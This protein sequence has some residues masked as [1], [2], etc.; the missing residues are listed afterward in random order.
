MFLNTFI[1]YITSCNQA[2][3]E[4]NFPLFSLSAN[5]RFCRERKQ[6]RRTFCIQLIFLQQNKVQRAAFQSTIR[7]DAHRIRE[8]IRLWILI[9]SP[10]GQP[11]HVKK[12]SQDARFLKPIPVLQ[13][14]DFEEAERLAKTNMMGFVLLITA[15]Y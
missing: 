15:N 5:Q 9:N 11:F 2:N 4:G 6:I 1:F 3:S 10:T 12:N 7:S 13:D 8:F 14:I